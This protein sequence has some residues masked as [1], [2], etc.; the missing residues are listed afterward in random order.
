MLSCI[1]A[2]RSNCIPL[3]MLPKVLLFFILL[4]AKWY[5]SIY[6]YIYII[7]RGSIYITM[8]VPSDTQRRG[9]NDNILD[10]IFIKIF[11][12]IF[13]LKHSIII[14]ILKFELLSGS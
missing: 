3:A 2:R 7:I 6:I 14:R 9:A 8:L 11:E 4:R 12:S 5:D 10:G 13:R 1:D